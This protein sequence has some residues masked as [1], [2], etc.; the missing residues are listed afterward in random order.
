[1]NSN[2][3]RTRLV[4]KEQSRR[5]QEG[6]L[7][8]RDTERMRRELNLQLITDAADAGRE[9]SGKVLMPERVLYVDSITVTDIRYPNRGDNVVK[10]NNR[11]ERGTGLWQ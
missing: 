10:T 11:K 1:M 5:E 9:P 6:R 4:K 3:V 2:G 8:L 7:I